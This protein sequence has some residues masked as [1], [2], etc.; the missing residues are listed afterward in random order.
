ME[1]KYKTVAGFAQAEI[2]EKKSRFIGTCAPVSNL[3]D[4]AAVLNKTRAQFEGAGHHAY[5]YF[6]DHFT[7]RYNDDGEPQKTA[8]LPILNVI[9]GNGLVKTLVIVTR[10]FGGILLG[11]GGLVKSYGLAAKLAVEASGIVE[12]VPRRKFSALFD[13]NMGLR[14]AKHEKNQNLYTITDTVYSD[15]IEYIIY[16]DLERENEFMLK[17]ADESHGRAIIEPL[18]VEFF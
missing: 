12:R 4:I 14:I 17:M 3:D 7:T 13:Y 10:Y 16:V 9:Q 5:A 2:V 6:I 11:T 1:Q 8:G 15:I 18:G